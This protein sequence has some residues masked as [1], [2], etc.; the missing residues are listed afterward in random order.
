[1]VELAKQA[2][3]SR[4]FT[5]AA[6]IYDRNITEHGPTLELY[7]GLADSLARGGQF[8]LAFDAHSQAL[9]HG[10]ISPDQ[11]KHLVL[12]LVEFLGGDDFRIHS[13]TKEADDMFACEFCKGIWK[14][15]ITVSCG[16]TFCRQCLIKQNKALNICIT[17]FKLNCIVCQ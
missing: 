13:E 14:D 9:L 5:L 16:H 2:F 10:N 3:S 1:M 11:L 7:M 17:L 15:P 4:N 12:A 8:K 6:E